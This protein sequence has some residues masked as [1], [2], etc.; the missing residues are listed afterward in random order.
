MLPI[1]LLQNPVM[2][3]FQ[4]SKVPFNLAAGKVAVRCGP[5]GTTHM[6]IDVNGYFE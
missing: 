4:Q 2:N 3:N 6:I 5:T 1:G